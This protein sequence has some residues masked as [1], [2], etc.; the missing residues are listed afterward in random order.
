MTSESARAALIARLKLAIELGEAANIADVQIRLAALDVV[1]GA[2]DDALAQLKAAESLVT[3]P[4][5]EGRIHYIRGQA[6]ARNGGDPIPSFEQ[7]AK[8]F[9]ASE[10]RVDELRARLRRVEAFQSQ[11]RID[12]AITAITEMIADLTE[13]KGDR[14]LIDC[15]R[16]R[17]GLHALMA[18][19]DEAAADYDEA[20]FA[21]ERHG[22][23]ALILRMKLE[24]RAIQPLS[25]QGHR[26]SW[27]E[28]LREATALQDVGAAGD[29]RL[30]QAADALRA[31]NFA[32]GERLA[33]AAREAGLDA[34]HPIL[35]TMACLLIA[36][37]REHRGN[38]QGVIQI[39]LTCK[40]TLEHAFGREM[41]EP[42]LSVL[43]SLE[44]RWG[45]PRFARALAGYRAWAQQRASQ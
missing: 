33:E 17:A 9:R 19:F 42:V 30:Q 26:D 38:D 27:T 23:D 21:A 32:E 29:I 25:F 35:Y 11:R 28:L 41:A 44:P 1:E 2:Y 45:Q 3:D 34:T 8:C 13:W 20:V 24:R 14:G 5:G 39:L 31:D 36:E 6:L 40:A 15:Y 22:D 18:R 7:A 37:A 10:Q 4:L 12:D 16:L 43:D